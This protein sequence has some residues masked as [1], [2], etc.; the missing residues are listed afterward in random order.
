MTEYKSINEDRKWLVISDLHL[1]SQHQDKRERLW[2]R[3]L[4][5]IVNKSE[6]EAVIILGDLYDRNQDKKEVQKAHP[7]LFKWLD[8]LY[9]L[10]V[11][12]NNDKNDYERVTL[13]YKDMWPIV[14]MH[15]H[16]FFLRY[17][18]DFLWKWFARSTRKEP[19]YDL[20]FS[21]RMYK[22][23]E[24]HKANIIIGHTHISDEQCHYYNCGSF[25]ENSCYIIISKNGFIK[26]YERK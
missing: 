15:G 2:V 5:R 23:A 10:Y 18:F 12:G 3:R 17:K 16:Q 14:L 6:I 9:V 13:Q 11:N 19:K 20:S 22:W 1:T 21:L 7:S 4:K 26:L 8:T 25:V 24:K